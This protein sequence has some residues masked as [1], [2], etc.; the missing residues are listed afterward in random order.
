MNKTLKIIILII[1]MSLTLINSVSATEDKIG[2]YTFET[3]TP[4]GI[5][6]AEKTAG[7]ILAIVRWV[8]V[9]VSVISLTIIGIK[10]MFGSLEEK[11]QYKK[12]MVPFAVGIIIVSLATTITTILFE[13]N[14]N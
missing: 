5:E 10:Y 7:S 6:E 4:T 3:K 9:I 13:I 12:T 1:L 8:A 11:A 14:G 2:G